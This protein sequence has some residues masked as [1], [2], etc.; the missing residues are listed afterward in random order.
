MGDLT[1]RRGKVLGMDPENG[2]T[3]I[4]ALVP[5]AEL[6]KYAASLRAMA[7]GR[8]FHTRRFS[9]Y[10]Q[11]PVTSKP[12]TSQTDPIQVAFLPLK[13]RGRV[14]LT[15]A[16][17][18]KTT[19]FSG[20]PWDRD[21]GIDLDRLKAVFGVDLLCPLIEDH[22]LIDMQIPGLVQAAE[23]R[24][25]VVARLPIPD[26]GTPLKADAEA[27]VRMAASFV[28]AGKT[29]VFHCKGGLGRAGTLSACTALWF[30][31]NA[32]EAIQQVRAVRPG[33]IENSAQER[34]I[35]DFALKSAK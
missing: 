34:F 20:S 27:L 23:E 11:V 3:V 16:P 26:G 25:I 21:L 31:N 7:Q 14:G 10:E 32:T 19:S 15:F 13:A 35:C 12:R 6:Y 8:A 33:A 2:R 1:Q 22:E 29:V 18:K 9:S 5:E 24:G 28:R 17:G 30:H 4:R